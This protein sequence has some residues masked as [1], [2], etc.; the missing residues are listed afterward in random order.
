MGQS[1]IASISQLVGCSEQ[2]IA[3]LESRYGLR[4]PPSDA[5]Y[6]QLMGHKSGRLFTSDHTAVFYRHVLEMTAEERRAGAEDGGPPSDFELPPDALLIAG[7]LGEQFEFIQCA[8]Q[9][10]SPV[11][12]FNTWDWRVRESHPSVLAWLESWCGEAEQAI[13]GGYD[14]T[15]PDGTIP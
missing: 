1:N 9:D 7:R 8:G 15:C 11:W 14:D 13:A 12:Y 3:T 6:L 4:L 10:D 2:E 5:M